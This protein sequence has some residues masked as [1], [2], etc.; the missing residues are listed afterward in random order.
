MKM[1]Y[2]RANTYKECPRKYKCRYIEERE[3]V[4]S[5]A[6]INGSDM[7][8]AIEAYTLHLLKEGLKTDMDYLA[9]LPVSSEVAE[10][11]ERFAE[12]H[13]L[14]PGKYSVEEFWDFP[15]NGDTWTA[16]IDRCKDEGDLVIIRDYKSDHNLRSQGDVDKDLQLKIYAAAA[17]H[18]FPEAKEFACQIDF[19][20]F[21]VVR[22]TGY[23][24]EDI[25]KIERE[26]IALTKRIAADKDYKPTPGSACEWCSYKADCEGLEKPGIT[27]IKGPEDVVELV[28]WLIAAEARIKEI[29]SLLKP[30]CTKEGNVI[31][32]G[33]DYG[34]H[35]SSSTSYPAVREVVEVLLANNIDPYDVL[36]IGGDP[37]KKVLKKKPE[38]EDKLVLLTQK[39]G[40]SQFTGVKTKGGNAE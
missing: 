18:K 7:H 14:E 13:I 31:V 17:S 20:R 28:E 2:T 27:A 16:K 37:M 30:H 21:G 36:R 9:N 8:E 5:D 34:W 12:T 22:E 10:L 33:I 1:S 32:N 38:L 6:L 23:F 29:K 40:S 39:S 3:E 26:M 24:R 4:K 11:I 15:L 35:T 19:V 25:P